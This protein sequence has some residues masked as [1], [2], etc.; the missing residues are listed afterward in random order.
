VTVY[1]ITWIISEKH[2]TFCTY[3]TKTVHNVNITVIMKVA[4]VSKLKTLHHVGT[5]IMKVAYVSKLK[6]L[7]H[8][9]TNLLSFIFNEKFR[10]RLMSVV[11][12]KLAKYQ[13]RILFFMCADN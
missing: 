5:V 2:Y 10:I 3:A 8:V 7:H 11:D 1:I 4:Y 13:T 6:T 12:N 9:G